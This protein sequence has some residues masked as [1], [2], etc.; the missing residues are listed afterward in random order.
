VLKHASAKQVKI[1]M[2]IDGRELEVVVADDGV[3]FDAT[4]RAGVGH[5]GLGNMARRMKEAGGSV[6]IDS[7]P[8]AGTRITFRVP[9]G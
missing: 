2:R 3:G 8:G 5:D 7:A 6:L 4:K 9:L 1:A